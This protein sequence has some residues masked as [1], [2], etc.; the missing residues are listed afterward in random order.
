MKRLD[1]NADFWTLL[2][3]TE[4]LRRRARPPHYS[5]VERRKYKRTT[6]DARAKL[7]VDPGP[8]LIPCEVVN[9]THKGAKLRSDALLFVEGEIVEFTFDNYR[10]IRKARVVW[11]K[12]PELG[13]EFD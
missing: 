11:A 12:A 4:A 5:L 6:V 7:I 13:I 9:L 3:A 1:Q 2:S 8:V 10:T